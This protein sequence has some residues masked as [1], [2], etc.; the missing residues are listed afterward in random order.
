MQSTPSP[1]PAPH[2]FPSRHVDG[3]GH[4]ALDP[5]R[6]LFGLVV[7][8]VGVL[9]LLEALDVLD[10]G[11]A[12]GRW[13]PAAIIAAGCL[14]LADRRSSLVGPLIVVAAGVLLLLDTTGAIEG[15][16]WDY[17]WPLAVVGIGLGILLGRPR[18]TIPADA[19]PDDTVRATGVFGEPKIKSLSRQFRHASLTAL[20]GG[21]TLDLREA[22]PDPAGA[23][24]TA[25]VAFG[26]IHVL[27]PHGWRVALS[28][29]PVF[30]GMNDK[31]EQA[32]ELAPDAPLLQVNGLA[33]FGGI[34]VKN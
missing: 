4:R 23:T 5:G 32:G 22:L 14:Q 24:I 11:D 18:T 12:I 19:A 10:A 6:L 34:E 9:Y 15:D 25:T 13:W 31:T 33:L 30:G 27:V 16:T 21:V 29:T 17:M 26:G 8:A 3:G 20:F 1:H 28:G 2:H 7:L